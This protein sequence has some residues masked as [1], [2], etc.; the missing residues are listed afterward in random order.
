[1]F[2]IRIA[3]TLL[4]GIVDLKSGILGRVFNAINAVNDRVLDNLIATG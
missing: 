1:M 3:I 4:G 2:I